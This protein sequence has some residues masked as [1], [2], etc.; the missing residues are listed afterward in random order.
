[1]KLLKKFTYQQIH[2]NY[3]ISDE[4]CHVQYPRD[5]W[6]YII[7]VHCIVLIF[8]QHSHCRLEQCTTRRGIR[9]L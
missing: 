9:F 2:D 7:V 1:M 4:K 8:T 3:A 5:R 6:Y